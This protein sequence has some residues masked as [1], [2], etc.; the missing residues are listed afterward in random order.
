MALTEI[1]FIKQFFRQS[2]V[3]IHINYTLK[4]INGPATS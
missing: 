3:F 1:S 2:V 4:A